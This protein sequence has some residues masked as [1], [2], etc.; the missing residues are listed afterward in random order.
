[1]LNRATLIRPSHVS[2]IAASPV[3]SKTAA[4]MALALAG[5]LGRGA[6]RVRDVRP[7]LAATIAGL[8]ARHFG[9]DYCGW[10][11]RHGWG[12]QSIFRALIITPP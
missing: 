4:P 7:T 9:C 12:S 11:R 8:P 5:V 10:P 3:I 2:R 6:E 1:M